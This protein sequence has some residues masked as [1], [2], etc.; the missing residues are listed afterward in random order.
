[1]KK[2]RLMW[3]KKILQCHTASKWR[4]QTELRSVQPKPVLSTIVAI[5]TFLLTF[6]Y[7][8]IKI[9]RSIIIYVLIQVKTFS[10][11]KT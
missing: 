3:I 2:F 5:F 11:V 1:M 8:K 9:L 7:V 6:V 4:A 10:T